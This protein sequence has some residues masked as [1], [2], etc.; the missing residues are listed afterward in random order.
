MKP[1][2]KHE[3]VTVNNAFTACEDTS[4]QNP[5][6]YGL[7]K[8]MNLARKNTM[9]APQKTDSLDKFQWPLTRAELLLT[10]KKSV[11]CCDD[12][13]GNQFPIDRENQTIAYAYS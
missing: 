7:W 12:L 4:T 5:W 2:R 3:P 10:N 6:V 11:N 13:E 8:L 9:A 1:L